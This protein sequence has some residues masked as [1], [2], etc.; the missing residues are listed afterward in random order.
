MNRRARASAWGLALIG[1]LGTMGCATHGHHADATPKGGID[2][3]API[4]ARNLP[5]ID[6]RTGGWLGWDG[7]MG[8]IA[9]AD[10]VVVGEVH[11]HPV[12]GAASVALVEDL[13]AQGSGRVAVSLEFFDRDTQADVDDYLCGI[14]DEKAF[15]DRTRRA[16]GNYPEAHRAMVEVARNA[17]RPV[18]ASNA[19]RRYATVA[20]RE[21][22]D[23]LRG[24]AEVQRR[25]FVVPDG[26]TDGP[27]RDRFFGLMAGMGASHG[28]PSDAEPDPAAEAAM[29][30]G[31]FRAQCLWDATM[32]ASIV[33]A[34]ARG[35][36]PVVHIVGQFH[37]DFDGGVVQRVHA[38]A[39]GA[40]VVTVSLVDATVWN[41]KDRGRADVVVLIG[42]RE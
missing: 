15:R 39:P 31:F 33:E 7:L 38:A 19:P 25:L 35:A 30:E 1:A 42:K 28:G 12:G 24:L 29:I 20:R 27:Y 14:A 41:E 3:D 26:V 10:V 17:G 34:V 13:V 37:S 5:V 9:G 11:G 6:G 8:R 2:G 23:R 21:G 18:I 36:S 4:A 22:Y 16:E 40:R 32:A